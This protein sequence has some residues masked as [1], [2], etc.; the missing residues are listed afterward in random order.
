MTTR[1]SG[2]RCGVVSRD[3]YV[4]TVRDVLSEAE[5]RAWI[6]DMEGHGFEAAPISTGRGFVMSPSIRNNTRV[7]I[8]D[9]AWAAALWER[10]APFVPET[11]GGWG[12]VGLNER[13][14][15][16]RYEPGQ[17]FRWHSDGAFRRSWQEASLLTCMVYLND[18]G[19]E[20]GAT[21]FS[22]FERVLPETG[23]VLLFDH[24]LMH[25]GAP[26]RRGVKYVLRTDV[27][28]RRD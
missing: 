11:I 20:G 25:Q 3:P 13:F 10:L 22:D 12:A 1:R 2:M 19:L 18:E 9:V 5:C 27:M 4:A 17:Y 21:E 6:A 16:Y 28:Y 14:R 8:D 15:V 23:K 7:M 26:V 24:P